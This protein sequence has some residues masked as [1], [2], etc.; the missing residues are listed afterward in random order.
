[1][2]AW[3]S[4]ICFIR[5]TSLSTLQQE[6][7]CWP[8]QSTRALHW[9]AVHFC[10]LMNFY[11]SLSHLLCQC[12]FL[13]VLLL[14]HHR[15]LTPL[16]II[17][18]WLIFS[19]AHLSL[20]YQPTLN[21]CRFFFFS[22]RA[23]TW[24]LL[25]ATFS[26]SYFPFCGHSQFF[27]FSWGSRERVEVINWLAHV[28]GGCGGRV[29]LCGLLCGLPLPVAVCHLPSPDDKWQ[30]KRTTTILFCSSTLLQ[31]SLCR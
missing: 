8:Q 9:L 3:K 18:Q 11:L 28:G 20:L 25:A 10:L 16:F 14:D 26:S 1:M 24:S 31:H 30:P 12:V 22:W 7:F 21:N 29:V 5:S 27:L 13:V 6:Y 15:H 23:H 17:Y 4:P 2:W 19:F